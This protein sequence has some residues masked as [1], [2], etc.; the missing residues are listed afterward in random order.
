[1]RRDVAV[2]GTLADQ[3]SNDLAEMEKNGKATFSYFSRQT[4]LDVEKKEQK[5]QQQQ[6]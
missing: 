1:M 3:S 6:Q 2:I 5:K 4:L